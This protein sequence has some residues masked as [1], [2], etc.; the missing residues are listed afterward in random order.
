MASGVYS[1]E[2]SGK[3]KRET[4]EL[5]I[6]TEKQHKRM[7]ANTA[8]FW[9]REGRSVVAKGYKS[10][11]LYPGLRVSRIKKMVYANPRSDISATRIK[12]TNEFFL[13]PAKTPI[14][15][16]HIPYKTRRV[17]LLKK[18]GKGAS[19]RAKGIQKKKINQILTKVF[20]RP[21][22][23]K[24]NKSFFLMSSGLRGR[25][26]YAGQPKRSEKPLTL[27]RAG[28]DRKPLKLTTAPSLNLSA[29]K[30]TGLHSEIQTKLHHS[31]VDTLNRQSDI[32]MRRLARL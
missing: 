24:D 17:P 2:L 16:Y 19:S 25:Y 3:S 21:F 8:K 7:L 26:F 23:V 14:N 28:D 9:L 11:R 4:K 15:T 18:G 30:T 5:S 32:E 13:R 20:G 12:D 27:A 31:L 29:E 22:E 10:R 6:L 1:L